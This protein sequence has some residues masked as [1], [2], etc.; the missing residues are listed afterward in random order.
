MFQLE[1]KH[2]LNGRTPSRAELDNKQAL[3]SMEKDQKIL[4]Q[5]YLKAKIFIKSHMIYKHLMQ[6]KAGYSWLA[7]SR[8]YHTIAT[9]PG[10]SK[11]YKDLSKSVEFKEG[12]Q[13]V[14]ESFTARERTKTQTGFFKFIRD[15]H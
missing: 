7:L 9:S 14:M 13:A 1:Q 6:D 11:L 15:K 4:I 3:N 2:L 12:F 5:F 8:F 10:C